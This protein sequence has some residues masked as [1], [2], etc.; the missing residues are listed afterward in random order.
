MHS[1]RKAQ[2]PEMR[3]KVAKDKPTFQGQELVKKT[4]EERLGILSLIPESKTPHRLLFPR[5]L[6][7]LRFGV[8][9][10]ASGG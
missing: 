1:R 7:V 8:K 10:L 9:G 5:P 3:R 6:L 4:G 2:L